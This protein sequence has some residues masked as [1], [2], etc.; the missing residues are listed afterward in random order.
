MLLRAFN[1]TKYL[2]ELTGL[3]KLYDEGEAVFE[4]VDWDEEG[5]DD[6]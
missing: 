2:E 4:S 3:N 1:E 5:E 6:F